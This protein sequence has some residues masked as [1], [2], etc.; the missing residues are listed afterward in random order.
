ME[1][2][3][4]LVAVLNIVF[5]VMGIVLTCLFTELICRDGLGCMAVTACCIQKVT[6]IIALLVIILF[7][8]QIIAGIGLLVKPSPRMRLLA[9]KLPFWITL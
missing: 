8:L 6:P 7:V 1:K 9:K 5:G 3:I 2:H 4:T